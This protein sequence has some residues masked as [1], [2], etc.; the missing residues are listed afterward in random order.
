MIPLIRDL[1]LLSLLSG[2][3]YRCG[4]A[5]WGHSKVRDAGC[6]LIMLI[7]MWRLGL[8]HWSLLI[9]FGLMWLALSTYRYF[10]P[11]THDKKWYYFSLHGFFT[12]LA[13]LPYIY[14]THCWFWFW[15][16]VLA[17]TIVI[18]FW[19]WWIK[20]VDAEEGIRGFWLNL[21]LG[22]FRFC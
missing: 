8:W 17:L 19:S 11:K 10:L 16:R 7:T 5:S 6:S 14:F 15:I 21:S 22:L 1:V 4:G 3:L 18:G 2:F 9:S 13:L 12:G 20:Q